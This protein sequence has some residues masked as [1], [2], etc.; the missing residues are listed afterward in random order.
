MS[1]DIAGCALPLQILHLHVH[2]NFMRACVAV[3]AAVAQRC[4]TMLM[5]KLPFA[6]HASTMHCLRC[7]V[8]ECAG[9]HGGHPRLWRQPAVQPGAHWR[10]GR[11]WRRRRPGQRHRRIQLL[12]QRHHP[13]VRQLRPC[14]HMHAQ[15]QMQC[16]S[17]CTAAAWACT[18]HAV[19]LRSVGVQV[20]QAVSLQIV[21]ATLMTYA[22]RVAVPRLQGQHRPA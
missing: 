15:S 9:E 10:Q 14:M 11:G 7:R 1:D 18:W 22:V 2:L 21:T 4:L 16:N 13:G 19:Q 3:M 12:P 8:A 6:G 5:C 20:K 17:T